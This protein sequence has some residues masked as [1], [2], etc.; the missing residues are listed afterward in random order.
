M[1]IRS[2]ILTAW[3]LIALSWGIGGA[4][5]TLVPQELLAVRLL[6]LGLGTAL[7]VMAVRMTFPLAYPRHR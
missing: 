2:K 1:T 5:F 6:M 3:A 7:C 4:T